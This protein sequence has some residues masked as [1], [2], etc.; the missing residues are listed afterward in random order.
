MLS[1]SLKSDFKMALEDPQKNIVK[2]TKTWNYPASLAISE[3]L[4]IHPTNFLS[5][6][7]DSQFFQALIFILVTR[8][9]VV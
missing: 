5:S 6:F 8:H 1:D 2:S 9:P 4:I 3:T 7:F